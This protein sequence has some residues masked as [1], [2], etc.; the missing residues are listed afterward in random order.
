MKFI[1][2]LHL[3]SKY[4]RGTSREMNLENLDRIGREKG[5]LLL[6]TG[7]FTHPLW[8]SEIK[9]KLEE[10]ERGLFKLK[11]KN[12]P[13]RFLLTTE[14]NC[15]YFKNNRQR[16]V[17]FILFSPSFEICEKINSRLSLFGNLNSD[18]RPTLALDPKELLKILLDIS[19]DIFLI[20]SHAWTPWF[21]IF[22][23]K[24]G[25]DSIEECFEE[26]SSFIFSIE[27]GLS[28]DPPM[29]W[30][31]SALDKITL[32]SF[33]DAHSLE[34]VGREACVFDTSL[35][36]FAIFE[37]IKNKDKNKFL[38]TIEFF[39]EEGKYHYDGH[40]ECGVVL[41]PKET[42]KFNGL[43]PVCG[44]ALT[45]GVL[46]RVEQLAD[47]PEGF[48]PE[49]AIPYK[50]IVPLQEIL[51]EVFGKSSVSTLVQE[52]YKKLVKNF[53]GELNIL[54]EISLE[55][56]EKAT[57]PEIAEAIRRIREG[58]VIKEPGYDG[59]YGKIKIFKNPSNS[60]TPSQ[61]TLF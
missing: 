47:R 56:I 61:Q 19:P 48:I 1:A 5:V 18:G 40:R 42:K 2:D 9:E 8:L 26:L 25:F 32:V 46:N 38:Y 6:G 35:D 28:S 60:L 22:G 54:L 13:I 16:R 58:K 21:G 57:L 41:H 45:I 27:T 14:V 17:H 49:N 36:Y 12:S 24:S 39:P 34:K 30:R 44:K 52:E 15:I 51:A 4:S 50:S 11:G 29:N 3:H 10:K 7:D 43:C 59:V 23:S 55:E 53:E 37:A 20:P 31:V 33:S